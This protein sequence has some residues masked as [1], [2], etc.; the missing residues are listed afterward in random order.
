SRSIDYGR[1]IDR[2]RGIDWRRSIDCDGGV[3]CWRRVR[4]EL[5]GVGAAGENS[6]RD[7][8]RPWQSSH[9]LLL[10]RL[11]RYREGYEARRGNL[12]GRAAVVEERVRGRRRA[13]AG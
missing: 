11:G 9:G 8:K 6:Q 3:H 4:W 1:G 13:L 7:D 10:L 12:R 5:R 2:R